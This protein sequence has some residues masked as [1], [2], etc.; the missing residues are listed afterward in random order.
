MLWF[1]L[2]FIESR[3]L[4]SIP[5]DFLYQLWFS[6]CSKIGAGRKTWQLAALSSGFT[7]RFK[8]VFPQ[9]KQMREGKRKRERAASNLWIVL[10]VIIHSPTVCPFRWMGHRNIGGNKTYMWFTVPWPTL[11]GAGLNA[12]LCKTCNGM[13]FCVLGQPRVDNSG[14]AWVH[15]G[16]VGTIGLKD[17]SCT[18]VCSFG[19]CILHYAVHLS[20]IELDVDICR[21]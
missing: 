6:N 8:G 10:C 11:W 18:V 17:R 5:S 20:N 4:G 19:Y 1:F 2:V 3:A 14:S 9:R 15:L 16:A 12:V 7:R 21:Y 13:N